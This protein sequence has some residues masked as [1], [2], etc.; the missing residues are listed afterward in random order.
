MSEPEPVSQG[1][2]EVEEQLVS[3]PPEAAVDNSIEQ[4]SHCVSVISLID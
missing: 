3:E 4:V 2:G 1:E